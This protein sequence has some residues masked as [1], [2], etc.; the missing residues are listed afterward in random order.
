[1]CTSNS[2]CL[3]SSSLTNTLNAEIQISPIPFT[4][5]IRIN[6]NGL[7]N[8]LEEAN[9]I[10]E[11]GVSMLNIN[12]NYSKFNQTLELDTEMLNSGY[13]LIQFRMKDHLLLYKKIVKL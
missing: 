9:I 1:Y 12:T 2:S 13:Y 4:N 11:L 5:N 10:N 8:N 7:Q 3:L 6:L